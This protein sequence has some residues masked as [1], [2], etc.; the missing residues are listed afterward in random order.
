M[1]EVVAGTYDIIP[2]RS[3]LGEK[4]SCCRLLPH[5]ISRLLLPLSNRL[6]LPPLIDRSA[7]DAGI[8]VLLRII[9]FACQTPLPVLFDLDVS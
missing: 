8:V 2:R 4:C 7:C 5:L 1:L 3:E 9:Y 6:L